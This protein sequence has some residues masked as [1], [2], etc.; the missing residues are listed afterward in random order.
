[1]LQ[2]ATMIACAKLGPAY[3]TTQCRQ[4]QGVNVQVLERTLTVSVL[5]LA[6]GPKGLPPLRN[7]MPAPGAM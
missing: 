2:L 1:M 7:N 3:K 6:A 4:L 5:P